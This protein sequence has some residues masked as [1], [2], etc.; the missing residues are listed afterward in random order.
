MN[1][2]AGSV[3]QFLTESKEKRVAALTP[4]I[5]SIIRLIV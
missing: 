4:V 3:L 2:Q 1:G 5:V